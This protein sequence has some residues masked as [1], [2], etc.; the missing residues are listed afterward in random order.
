MRDRVWLVASPLPPLCT[1]LR[2]L[3]WVRQPPL[4]PPSNP[5]PAQGGRE[6]GPRGAAAAG[7]A[8][9]AGSP[10]AAA[11][12]ELKGIQFRAV[13][14]FNRL[15]DDVGRLGT[16][17]DTADLR[18]RIAEGSQ[19]F[20]ALAVEFRQRAAQHPVRNSSAAQKLLRDFQ[21]LLRSSEKLMETAKA[22]EAASLPR[23]AAGAAVAAAAQPP[24]ADVERQ[25]L[26]EAQRKQEV[27]SVEGAL[28]FN[29]AVIEER[30]QAITE[31]A[32]QIGEV[33]AAFARGR[34]VVCRVGW[35]AAAVQAPRPGCPRSTASCLRGPSLPLSLC[36]NTLPPPLCLS[37]QVHQIF[38]DLAVLVVDQGAQLDDI[39]ANLTRAAERA[40]D[41]GVQIARAERSQRAARS[42][43]CFLL[44][45]TA[46][47][48]LLLLL[49]ILA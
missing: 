18:R 28:Q 26:L 39:E 37:P 30:D 43:W 11:N 22:R 21:G 12:A 10:E 23:P 6:L 40:G 1:P 14:A 16:P 8:A 33:G 2:L 7:G 24:S 41:A 15:R 19:R 32:G 46:A 20:K 36:H 49:I 3:L 48:V 31:I 38:Q 35:R 45:I 9:G 5:H 13:T 47:V 29:E 4:T 25:A 42:K 27:L 17:A 34:R 44:A